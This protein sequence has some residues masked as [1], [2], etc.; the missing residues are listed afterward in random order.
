MAEERPVLDWAKKRT[1]KLELGLEPESMAA[2]EP[3]RALLQW[4]GFAPGL[5]KLAAEEWLG[6][7][8]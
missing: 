2:R 6:S 8:A 3:T 7:V 4:G 5:A 1:L